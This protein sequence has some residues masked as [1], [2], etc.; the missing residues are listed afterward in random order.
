MER[1]SLTVNGMSCEHCERAVKNSMED[2]GVTTV[3]IS[4][5]QN[6]AILEYDPSKTSLDDIKAE[7][8]DTGYTV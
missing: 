7:I 1:I 8:I 6:T 3:S 5:T 4:H 2:I